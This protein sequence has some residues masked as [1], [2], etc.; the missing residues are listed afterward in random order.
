[1]SDKT[2][3]RKADA[4]GEEGNGEPASKKTCPEPQGLG[5]K[6]R[7]SR[8]SICKSVAEFKFNKKRVRVLSKTLDCP[9]DSNGILY[10]MSRDQR[11]QGRFLA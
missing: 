9:E 2:G 10:W 6:I 1:M 11:V 4:T 3:K 7:M 8:L 5:E